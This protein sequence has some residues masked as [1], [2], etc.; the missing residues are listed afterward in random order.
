MSMACVSGLGFCH[1]DAFRRAAGTTRARKVQMRMLWIAEGCACT[2]FWKAGPPTTI[3]LPLTGDLTR[4]TIF[5]SLSCFPRMTPFF[6]CSPP[7][8]GLRPAGVG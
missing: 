4:V 5:F 2:I 1:V 3:S 7:C 8:D 6:P